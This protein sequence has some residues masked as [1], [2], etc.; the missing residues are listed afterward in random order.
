MQ[1][2]PSLALKSCFSALK[3]LES[4]GISK[5]LRLLLASGFISP[6]C[7]GIYHLMAPALS[8]ISKLE[9]TIDINMRKIGGTKV[10]FSNLTPLS[11]W[12]Q[13]GRVDTIGHEL[14][15]LKD[16][17]HRKYCLSPTHEEAITNLLSSTALISSYKHLP[18]KLYQIT[19][20]YRDE[21]R[22]RYG[23]LR[24]REFLMKDL[25]SFDVSR[26][27]AMQTYEQVSKAY[28]I[29]FCE[30]D[31]PVLKTA[32]DGE[33]MGGKL[34]HEFQL[35]CSIGE[36]TLVICGKCNIQANR[37]VLALNSDNIPSDCQSPTCCER[38]EKKAVELA[39]IFY[40]GTTY[41]KTFG[42]RY[43][44]ASNRSE[45]VEMG[46]Y[47]LGVSRVLGALCEHTATRFP[48]RLVWPEK[49]APYYISI[50]PLSSKESNNCKHLE[51]ASEVYQQLD[52]I[53]SGEI[54]IDNRMQL[55]HSYKLKDSRLFGFPYSIVLS[56]KQ[57]DGVE[58][59]NRR[60]NGDECYYYFDTITDS[61]RFLVE[62]LSLR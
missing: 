20:K 17:K 4:D 28:E 44:D 19:T 10:H 11:L 6:A 55:S 16:S 13:S 12:E 3:D 48:D 30:L 61:V 24:C 39:H 52:D 59:I 62:K 37:D 8:F 7:S 33:S 57:G 47:G 23:L 5:G 45:L 42:L 26:E 9:T 2:F 31:L 50:I 1:S 43:L 49:L 58:V 21:M 25:Y 32:A 51:R 38:I 15:K 40:I 54:V 27:E 14:F 46:C 34:S 18:L 35:P 53:F 60:C 29:I 56:D 41:S 36:N 22:P